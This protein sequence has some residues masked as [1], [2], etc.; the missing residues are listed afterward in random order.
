MYKVIL[1]LIAL[2][3]ATSA[4]ANPNEVACTNAFHAS[5]VAMTEIREYDNNVEEVIRNVGKSLTPDV[6][7]KY[8]AV[9]D[10]VLLTL[11]NNLESLTYLRDHFECTEND[12]TALDKI[13]ARI[14]EMENGIKHLTYTRSLLT[15]N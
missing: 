7:R 4:Y 15:A 5:S 13:V 14:R 3:T 8:I 6:A 12:N 11:R 2:T 1:A 9:F 10:R